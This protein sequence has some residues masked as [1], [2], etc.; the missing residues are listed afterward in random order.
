MP[1]A[2]HMTALVVGVIALDVGQQMMQVAN[3]TRIFGLGAN[4]RSRLNTI[5]MTVYFTGGAVGSAL[6][7]F[8]WSRWG[9]SGVCILALGFIGTAGLRHLTGYSKTHAEALVSVPQGEREPA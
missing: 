5:Y 8:A 3:Q 2:A 7:G 1:V 4:V 6:A 9:W